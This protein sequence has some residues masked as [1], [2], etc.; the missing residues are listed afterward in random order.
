MTDVGI[1]ILTVVILFH[2][3]RLLLL[4]RAPGKAFAPNRW[5]GIGGKVEPSELSDLTRAAERELFEETDLA[6]EEV[7]PLRLRRTL[8]F[9]R[10]GEGLVCLLYFTG[11]T[12]SDRV[13][14]CNEGSLA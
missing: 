1:S 8:T 3:G 2:A 12:T 10:P 7:S 9:D 5:T 6:P 11:E 4:R 14:G 13:P